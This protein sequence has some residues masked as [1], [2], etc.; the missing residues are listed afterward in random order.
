MSDLDNLF[1]QRHKQYTPIKR[2]FADESS[3]HARQGRTRSREPNKSI[4]KYA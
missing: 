2:L 3:S 4:R 1:T